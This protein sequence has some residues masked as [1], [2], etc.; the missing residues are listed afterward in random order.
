MHPLFDE[1][2]AAE[3][4]IVVAHHGPCLGGALEMSL[5]CDFRLAAAS[6]SYAL[7][8]TALGSLPG[9]GG[10]SRLTRLVGPHW[11]RWFIMANLPMS[12]ERALAAGLIHDIYPDEEFEQRVRAFCL[13]LARQTPEAVAAAK[14]AIEM[15][16]DL[17]RSEARN[18]ERLAVSA[19]AVGE[20]S[21]SLTAKLRNRLSN[22]KT[23]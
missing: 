17:G 16:A 15:V 2:E 11:A 5:S 20:E 6:A 19:L 3:K 10:T 1:L 9:S 7:P 18:A 23:P 22:K 21:R 4:P 8:E 13:H 12:A 14:I